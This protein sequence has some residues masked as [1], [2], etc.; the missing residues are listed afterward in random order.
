MMRKAIACLLAFCA[1]FCMALPAFA[2][3]PLGR[4]GVKL[5]SDVAGLTE[6]DYDKLFEIKYGNVEYN[7][8]PRSAGP[9]SVSNYVG[10][11]EDGKLVAGRSYTIYYG[12]VPKEG[13][14]LPE[15]ADD[16]EL[17]IECGKGVRVITTQI[18]K[19]TYRED[20]GELVT[21]RAIRIYAVVVVD[22][23]AFQRI[24]GWFH[25]LILKIRSWQID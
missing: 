18:T 10:A 16:L 25:D 9:A 13:Y 4:F 14:E 11:G 5:N 3:E 24:I 21:R 7:L 6:E 20:N 8:N 23:N 19:G 12:L 15:S 1:V 17:E 2:A 22:G